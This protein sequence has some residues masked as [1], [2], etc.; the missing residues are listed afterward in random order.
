MVPDK[1]W[2]LVFS[3]CFIFLVQNLILTME[4]LQPLASHAIA[5]PKPAVLPQVVQHSQVQSAGAK[6][7][8]LGA[9]VHVSYIARETQKKADI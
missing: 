7:A 6:N 2:P 1:I 9:L 5:G 3:F 8:T 4:L